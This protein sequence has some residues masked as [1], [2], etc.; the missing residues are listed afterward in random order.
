MAYILFLCALTP[1]DPN[2][3]KIYSLVNYARQVI[4][5][6]AQQRPSGLCPVISNLAA[7]LIRVGHY[8]G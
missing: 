8:E 7:P 2:G 3:S 1:F 6:L 4:D 5:T